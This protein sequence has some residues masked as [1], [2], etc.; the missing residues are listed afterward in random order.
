MSGG[1]FHLPI[2]VRVRK[3]RRALPPP[4]RESDAARW[5]A[6]IQEAQRTRADLA[7]SI[8]VD[9]V[10]LVDS[11]SIQDA[12]HEVTVIDGR[13]VRCSCWPSRRGRPCA[14][15]A[16]VAVRLWEMEMGADLSQVGALALL[17]TL[18]NRY[19]DPPRARRSWAMALDHT[20]DPETRL[21]TP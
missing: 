19:L 21:V 11:A 16:F 6:A 3:V 2:G 8:A 14:H 1:R 12:A 18:L 20:N 9:G 4:P 17:S 7:V 15:R 10:A 13:A 5:L